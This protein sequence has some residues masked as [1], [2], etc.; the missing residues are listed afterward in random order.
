MMGCRKKNN[1]LQKE[2]W[3][4]AEKRIMGCRKKNDGVAERRTMD[5]KK[6]KKNKTELTMN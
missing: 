5:C 2:E 3:W 1:G 4:V 6:T